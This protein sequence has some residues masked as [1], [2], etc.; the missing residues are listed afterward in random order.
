[1]TRSQLLRDYV[2]LHLKLVCI[3]K[4]RQ[5]RYQLI[6]QDSQTVEIQGQ[7]IALILQDLWTE[8]LWASAHRLGQVISGEV[9]L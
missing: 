5:P 8:V 1:M 2:L 6:E 9:L 7:P 3:I 4:R